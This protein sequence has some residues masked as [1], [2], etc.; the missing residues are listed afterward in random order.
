MNRASSAPVIAVTEP[1]VIPAAKAGICYLRDRSIPG[2]I[3]SCLRRND[4]LFT[5]PTLAVIPIPCHSGRQSR[6]LLV[7]SGRDQRILDNRIQLRPVR[8]YFLYTEPFK[9][10]WILQPLFGFV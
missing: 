10:V 5:S 9:R 2:S 7:L 4:E 6:N 1:P 3:D 8:D